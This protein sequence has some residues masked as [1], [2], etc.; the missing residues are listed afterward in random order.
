M[1]IQG[2]FPALAT[3]FDADGNLYKEKVVHNIR[4][5][6]QIALGGYLVCGSTGETP[7][8]S[9]EERLHL[10]EWVKEASAPGKI[11][12]AGVGAESVHQTVNLANR[13]AEAGFHAALALT[14]FYYPNQM[15]RPDTQLLFFRAVADRSKLPVLL[16]NIPQVTNYDLSVDTIAELSH[17]PNIAGMKDSSGNNEKLAAVVQAVKPGFQVLSGSGGSFWEALQAGASGAILAIAN[18]LPY[19]CV[20]VWE[21]FRMRDHDAGRDWQQRIT[22]ASRLISAKHG[23]PGVKYAM[24]LNGY[25]GGPP[26][27][28]LVPPSADAKLEIEKALD[29]LRS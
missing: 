21:A 4:K 16:Y 24:E 6:N 28:P 1:K 25:Y 18:P 2:I 9:P 14:P 23:I 8:L 13:A 5:L 19:A 17:H 29:G 11:L 3:C 12:I 15:H 26:R 20:T 7:L 10:M 27:L 22:P